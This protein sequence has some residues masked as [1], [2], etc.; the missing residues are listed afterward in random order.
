MTIGGSIGLIILG[1]ILKF[2][3]TWSPKYV[4]IQAMGV[5][6]MIGGLVGLAISVGSLVMRRRSQMATQVTEQ[7]RYLERPP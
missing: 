4:N 1:A 3:I 6:L 7:R 2:A 5:I